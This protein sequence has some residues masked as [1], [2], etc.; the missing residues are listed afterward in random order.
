MGYGSTFHSYSDPEPDT[1]THFYSYAD[2]EPNMDT[3]FLSNADPERTRGTA[4]RKCNYIT[5]IQLYTVIRN[6]ILSI[7]RIHHITYIIHRRYKDDRINWKLST[8]N[9]AFLFSI[10]L[11]VQA[12]CI[13]GLRKNPANCSR[14]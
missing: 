12:L 13:F 1:D 6:H 8:S 11:Y 4:E 9:S 2:T 14:N 3:P 10:F 5:W 7:I